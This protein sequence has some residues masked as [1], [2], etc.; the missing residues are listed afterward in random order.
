VDS[1]DVQWRDLSTRYA[2]RAALYR[3]SLVLISAIIRLS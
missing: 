3:A 1:H 2:K